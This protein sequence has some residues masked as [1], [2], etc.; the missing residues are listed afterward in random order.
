MFVE[1]LYNYR[2]SIYPNPTLD[3]F[4]VKA[5]N[6]INEMTVDIFSSTGQ[7]VVHKEAKLGETEIQISNLSK[8]IYYVTVYIDKVKTSTQKLIVIE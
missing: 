2:I 3:N 7:Y 1:C 6:N 5:E 4:T 8:G